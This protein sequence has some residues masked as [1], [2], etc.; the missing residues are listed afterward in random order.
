MKIGVFRL[1][2]LA[3]AASF[4]LAAAAHAADPTGTWL[5]TNKRGDRVMKSTLTLVLKDGQLTGSVKTRRADTA[6]AGAS[7]KDGVVAFT[8]TREM[9]DQSLTFTYSG[10]L[11][12]DT[13]KGTMVMPGWDGGDPVTRPWTATRLKPGAEPPP[14][15]PPP[16]DAPPSN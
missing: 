6:I 4:L 3:A 14:P 9:R 11:D 5:W 7:F 2:I 8:V 16:P 12:G 1:T 10:T 15:P 13:I